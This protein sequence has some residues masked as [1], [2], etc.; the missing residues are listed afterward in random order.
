MKPERMVTFPAH[1]GV[2]VVALWY[3]EPHNTWRVEIRGGDLDGDLGNMTLEDTE[4]L[5]EALLRA[6]MPWRFPAQDVP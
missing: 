6:C 2:E 5:G 4:T 1:E 3:G